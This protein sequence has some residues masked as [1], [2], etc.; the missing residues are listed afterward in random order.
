MEG[1]RDEQ[2]G[3]VG[4]EAKGLRTITQQRRSDSRGAPQH[5][6]Q[7]SSETILP[8]V[9]SEGDARRGSVLPGVCSKCKLGSGAFPV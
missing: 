9:V 3:R 1:I 8:S 7:A 4:G 2:R 5:A 6:E